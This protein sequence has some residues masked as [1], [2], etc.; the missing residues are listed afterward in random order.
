[1]RLKHLKLAGFKSFVD[2]TVIPFTQSLSAV[3]GPNGCGKSNIIDAVRWVLG[4]S[5]AKNLRG[6]D[7]S[8]VIFNGS[9]ARKPVSIASVELLFDNTEGRAQ[10]PWQQF[11]EISIKRQ[12]SRQGQSDYYVNGQKCRRRDIADLLSGTGLGPR[13]YSIIEQG[14][15]SRLVESKPAEL[16]GFIE[17][18]AGISKYKERKRD[19]LNRIKNSRDNLERL[20]DLHHELKSQIDSLESQAKEAQ[21]Y[22]ALKKQERTLQT[23]IVVNRWQTFAKQLEQTRV[24]LE[25]SEQQLVLISQTVTKATEQA[26]AIGEGI[27]VVRENL[28]VANESYHTH[29]T[30]ITRLTLNIEHLIQAQSQSQHQFEQVKLKRDSMI[31]QIEDTLEISRQHEATLSA[32]QQHLAPLTNQVNEL[33]EA[34]S[35]KE[36]LLEAIE[37]KLFSIGNE[38]QQYIA[39]EQLF[40][41]RIDALNSQRMKTSSQIE[42]L[43]KKRVS[44]AK[45]QQTLDPVARDESYQLAKHQLL[46]CEANL[47]DLEAKESS[48]QT[49][50]VQN[51][52]EIYQAEQKIALLVQEQTTT[53]HQLDTKTKNEDDDVNHYFS[54]STQLWQAISIA[55]KWQLACDIIIGDDASA[56]LVDSYEVDAP[57]KQHTQ[58]WTV[59]DNQSLP[60]ASIVHH[61]TTNDNKTKAIVHR[62]L[63]QILCAEDRAQALDM[64]SELKANQM[65]VTP[66]GE[67]FREGGFWQKD[68][69]K[70]ADGIMQLRQRLQ[71]LDQQLEQQTHRLEH[72]Q[73][74][75]DKTSLNLEQLTPEITQATTQR[76]SHIDSSNA[77]KQ[78]WLLEQQQWEHIAT[79]LAEVSQQVDDLQRSNIIDSNAIND[80][81][82]SQSESQE[83]RRY[84]DNQ[85]DAL[86]QEKQLEKQQ[87]KRLQSKL[88]SMMAKTHQGELVLQKLEM[89]LANEQR[90]IGQYQ[91]TQAQLNQEFEQL[92]QKLTQNNTPIAEKQSQL[93]QRKQA[94]NNLNN[95]RSLL[96]EELVTLEKDRAKQRDLLAGENEK[97]S[98]QNKAIEQQRLKVETL[99]I[100]LQSQR[101]N[102][103]L[104]ER[105][106]AVRALEIADAVD[107]K[108]WPGELDSI[109][110]RLANM[111]AINLTAIEQYN[112][113]KQRLDE[114]TSQCDDLELGLQTLEKAI[115]KIDRQS[116]EKFKH[117]FNNV[118]QDFQR[119]F[120]KV[121]G[122]G[123]AQL[124]LTDSDLLLAGVSIM[125]QPPGKKNSTIHLL[126]GGEKALTALSLV[127]AIFQLNPAPFCM[128]DE[129]DAPLDDANVD[130]YC[131]LVN[132]MSEKVQ[133][134]YITHNKVSMEMANQLTGVT[135]QEAGVSRIVA[136]DVDEAVSM[137]QQ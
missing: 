120:P 47:Q 8:D 16:R 80:I 15:I 130:R 63:G 32:Q 124:T 117:T 50:L 4:E 79:N 85:L 110:D 111:G 26:T 113:Q 87:A 97:E 127:F 14:T 75:A 70:S 58:F 93:T 67:V 104:S 121:F 131:N 132:E 102:T 20:N 43:D 21:E 44:L 6:D 38:R 71:G 72:Y 37:S 40:S 42:L 126:S 24:S 62:Y 29:Q 122:G 61:I 118:N 90:Q 100:K 28:N 134:I 68:S 89:Q 5:S 96:Q 112:E 123:S 86:K 7:M 1:M 60:A 107:S 53:N 84:S 59:Q 83:K 30:E 94:Q 105:E 49:F 114:L 78:Q 3:V 108:L 2:P 74:L 115:K 57:T 9:N 88:E 19:T 17:D 65:I 27:K 48:L 136:V 101:Q 52:H 69:S 33:K 23:D 73:S 45:Q 66:L 39:Q 51:Q 76:Q 128:L 12:V 135:M 95:Q 10:G 11:S 82:E 106:M 125:A 36:S 77:C 54:S 119:L 109:R 41:Q 103:P 25:T 133:F 91:Q 55:P 22:T 81:K 31:M 18:A 56:Y 35:S 34:V 46:Q 137:A 92:E 64:L 13:S 129:V 99:K 116:R 98:L